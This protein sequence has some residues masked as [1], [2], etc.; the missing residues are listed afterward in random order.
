MGPLITE[1]VQ[2]LLDAMLRSRDPRIYARGAQDYRDGLDDVLHEFT[3]DVLLHEGQLGYAL[4]TAAD[5]HGFDRIINRQL[6]R[7]LARTRER[8]IVDNL[9]ERS[10]RLLGDDEQVPPR[11]GSAG[12]S[13]A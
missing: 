9:L 11:R 12:R 1:R 4:D 5:E 3:I 7:Y 8:S 6:R 2:G 10:L 13:S